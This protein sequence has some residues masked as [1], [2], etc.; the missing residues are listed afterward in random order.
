VIFI[1]RFI[2]VFLCIFLL[3][4]LCIPAFAV[5]IIRL[6]YQDWLW[7]YDLFDT[8]DNY[9]LWFDMYSYGGEQ[10]I[11]PIDVN[12]DEYNAKLAL[13]AVNDSESE[14]PSE[15]VTSESDN[16]SF[17]S[18]S[19][20]YPDSES[21][22]SF[23]LSPETAGQVASPSKPLVSL[24]ENV[25]TSGQSYIQPEMVSV[26][27]APDASSGSLLS[28]LYN[29]LGKPIV[30]Y[31]YK[32]QSSYDNSRFGYVTQH[33]EYDSNWLASL[34]LLLVVVFCIFKA[35]GALISKA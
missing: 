29:L 16:D 10:I 8:E 15:S 17:D 35:G 23:S 30:S 32:I 12:E 2:S 22:S 11:L 18:G 33:L 20:F 5:N 14:A 21:D 27:Y 26:E 1:K 9:S 13:E 24:A 19:V 31:T 7:F 3:V 34:V 4:C 6:E 28:V 25:P